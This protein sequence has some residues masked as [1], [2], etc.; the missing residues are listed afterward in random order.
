MGDCIA[1]K[2]GKD[3]DDVEADDDND[4]EVSATGIDP[5]SFVVVACVACVVVISA[6]ISCSCGGVSFAATASNACSNTL[7]S[8]PIAALH[9]RCT[10]DHSR[11]KCACER[12]PCESSASNA[13]RLRR[14]SSACECV[15]KRRPMICETM[16]GKQE[17]EN[18]REIRVIFGTFKTMCKNFKKK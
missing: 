14:W 17:N 7:Y 9:T 3:A 6:H 4:D 8:A 5:P 12:R 18:E 10:D 13:G 1:D 2:D 16:A 15:P 11:C